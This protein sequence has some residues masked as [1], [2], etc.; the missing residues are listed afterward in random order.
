[1]A[2][3]AQANWNAIRVI[4]KSEDAAIPMKDQQ[5]T[6]LF[7]WTQLLEKHTKADIRADLQYQHRLLYKQFKNVASL[8]EF[9][10]RYLAIRLW[11]LSFRATTVQGLSRLEL[12]LAS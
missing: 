11:W 4:Y 8:A 7:Y 10:T 2:D 6:C 12:W 5:R 9:E 3:N 1:M